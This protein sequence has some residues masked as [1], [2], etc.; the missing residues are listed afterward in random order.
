MAH[1]HVIYHFDDF[2]WCLIMLYLAI[3]LWSFPASLEAN[4]AV[5][6]P[7]RY[8]Y[9]LLIS[10]TLSWTVGMFLSSYI[11]SVFQILN[12]EHNDGNVYSQH[13]MGYQ[14]GN[15]FVYWYLRI[16]MIWPFWKTSSFP[17]FSEQGCT[18]SQNDAVENSKRGLYS[19]DLHLS[20]KWPHYMHIP[21]MRPWYFRLALVS[22][23]HWCY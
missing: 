21:L 17:D 11:C 10:L 15:A 16:S 9:C 14:R 13:T 20:E 3:S 2:R 4:R 19:R 6:S 1:L 8:Q 18:Q 7:C 5:S 23:L 12:L 22:V